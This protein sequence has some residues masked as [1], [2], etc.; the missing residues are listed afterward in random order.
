MKMKLFLVTL[1]AGWLPRVDIAQDFQAQRE[2]MVREQISQ[3]GI[4]DK[5]ILAAMK[6]VERH[7]FV[8][9]TIRDQA[10][11]DRA[12]PIGEGQTISQPYVVAFMTDALKVQL[13]D[14]VLEIGT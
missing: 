9:L 14:K 4:S 5:R 13:E 6:K 1:I 8:P 10:Y 7:K 2:I 11:D 3:R 12:Q